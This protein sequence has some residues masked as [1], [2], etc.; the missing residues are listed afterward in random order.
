MCEYLNM[1][2][3]MIMVIHDMIVNMY[4]FVYIVTQCM[5]VNYLAYAIHKDVAPSSLLSYPP[6]RCPPQRR[7]FGVS[8]GAELN[9]GALRAAERER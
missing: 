8:G 7:Q 2:A 4:T 3:Y 9:A 1:Q 5:A 6:D